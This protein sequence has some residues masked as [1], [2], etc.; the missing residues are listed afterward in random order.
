LWVEFEVA[1]LA[2]LIVFAADWHAHE[3]AKEQ[4]AH[5]PVSNKCG[6]NGGVRTEVADGG[7]NSTLRL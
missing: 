4:G 6:R 7:N 5:G 3:I 2:M 1:A